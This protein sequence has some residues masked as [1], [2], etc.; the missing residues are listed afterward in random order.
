MMSRSSLPEWI[1]FCQSERRK[2][3]DAD[4][5]FLEHHVWIEFRASEFFSTCSGFGTILEFIA[6]KNH[7]IEK[8][9]KMKEKIGSVA[10]DIW[11][12]LKERNEIPISEI[13][14]ILNERSMIVNQAIGWL[15]RENKLEFRIEGT[16]IFVSLSDIVK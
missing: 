1:R 8:E 6:L 5:C 9:A 14:R 10:G 15:A 2:K 7:I 12:I 3:Y 11:H 13:P 4:F 16:K